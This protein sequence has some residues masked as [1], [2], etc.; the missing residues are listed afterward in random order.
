MEENNLTETQFI[1][2][3]FKDALLSGMLNKMQ[4]GDEQDAEIRDSIQEL[5]EETKQVLTNQVDD[6]EFNQV[7]EEEFKDEI[8]EDFNI[9]DEELKEELQQLHTTYSER[10]NDFF[11]KYIKED[12]IDNAKAELYSI[13][14]TNFLDKIKT[15]DNPCCI[16]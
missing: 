8:N 1:D 3:M 12:E 9:I 6:E 10:L 16:L 4:V 2:N 7:L 11:K 13:M 15:E 14:M 5:V